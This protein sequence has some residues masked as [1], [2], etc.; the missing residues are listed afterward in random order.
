LDKRRHEMKD[1]AMV[2]GI[3]VVV[4]LYIGI[5]HLKGWTKWKKE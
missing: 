4:V 1:T 2:V 5:Q 3:T